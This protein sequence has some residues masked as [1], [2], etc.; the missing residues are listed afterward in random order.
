MGSLAFITNISHLLRNICTYK[1]VLSHGSDNL[2]SS[3]FYKVIFIY[4]KTDVITILVDW[5]IKMNETQK[6][7]F[8]YLYNE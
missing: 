4:S 1:L 3:W 5:L 8:D 7:T 2:I 6:Q